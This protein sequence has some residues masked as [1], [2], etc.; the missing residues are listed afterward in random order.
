MPMTERVLLARDA[1]RARPST[2]SAT[3]AATQSAARVRSNA[4]SR[5]SSKTRS[6]AGSWK[7]SS[8]PAPPSPWMRK[9]GGWYSASH[10]PGGQ[11]RRMSSDIE[12]RAYA[13]TWREVLALLEAMRDR[14][15][16]ETPLPMAPPARSDSQPT[17]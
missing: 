12:L 6:R 4:R 11:N 1:K 3:P 7:R 2:C 5:S 14:E 10:D 9:T 17:P 15:L 13:Q 16:N 8:S